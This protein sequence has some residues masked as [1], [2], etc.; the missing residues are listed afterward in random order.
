MR[1]FPVFLD[2]DGR[3]VV[4]AGGGEAASQKLRLILKTSAQISVFAKKI[5]DEFSG[6]IRAGRIRLH[7][8]APNTADLTGAALVY[9]ATGQDEADRS[10]A[11]LAKAAKV[12]VN[13]VD[14]PD[15]SDFLTPAIVDRDPVTVAI[16]TEGTAPV[17]ARRIKAQIEAL[18]PASTGAIARLAAGWRQRLAKMLPDGRARRRVW[19][20]FFA[21]GIPGGN[22]G[23][24]DA[25]G[26]RAA[27]IRLEALATAE[28]VVGAD[29]ALVSLIETTAD[30]PER[31]TAL[32]RR[33]LHNADVVVFDRGAAPRIRELARREAKFIILDPGA[34][35]L[36]GGSPIPSRAGD[37]LARQAQDG[38][39]IVRLLTDGLPGTAETDMIALGMAG[40]D[41][42]FAALAPPPDTEADAFK[43]AV[44]LGRRLATHGAS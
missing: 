7:R 21:N 44:R 30:D 17:L 43:H 10:F 36:G 2:L 25:P 41:Y 6:E 24:D 26:L 28:A 1:Y 31:L 29:A 19:Q 35:G 39:K 16:G 18:L 12:P 3:K 15:I 5:S 11:A 33:R 34:A 8:R 13:A 40:V 4:V 37:V 9:A 27:H 42:E 22:P 23:A 38:L 14:R 32:A 20:R